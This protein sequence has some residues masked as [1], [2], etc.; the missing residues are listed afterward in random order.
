MLGWP[1]HKIA[2]SIVPLEKTTSCVF[3]IQILTFIY[4]VTLRTTSRSWTTRGVAS[5][6]GSLSS[7][8]VTGGSCQPVVLSVLHICPTVHCHVPFTWNPQSLQDVLITQSGGALLPCSNSFG[9]FNKHSNSHC[10]VPV[11]SQMSK[12]TADSIWSLFLLIWNRTLWPSPGSLLWETWHRNVWKEHLQLSA[13]LK[14]VKCIS[15]LFLL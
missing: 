1:A 9:K 11:L 12:T 4:P 15:S 6:S 8:P 3:W 10:S 2:H 14:F 13:A 5:N 7:F